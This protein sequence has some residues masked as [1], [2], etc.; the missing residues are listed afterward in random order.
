MTEQSHE[1]SSYK[2]PVAD[3]Q[4]VRRNF[5]GYEENKYYSLADMQEKYRYE[6]AGTTDTDSATDNS[7][8]HKGYAKI[9]QKKGKEQNRGGQ[10]LSTTV[11]LD[12]HARNG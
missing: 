7:D 10:K 5:P 11:K 6:Q 2:L 12:K 4:K 9:Y 1:I 8:N 3:T